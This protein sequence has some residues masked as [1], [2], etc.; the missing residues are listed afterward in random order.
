MSSDG[1]KA[2]TC[3]IILRDFRAVAALGTITFRKGH[4]LCEINKF[5]QLP[6]RHPSGNFMGTEQ[7][8][9]VP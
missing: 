3:G 8:A 9:A 2:Q 5:E 7:V 4:T 6:R 1:S